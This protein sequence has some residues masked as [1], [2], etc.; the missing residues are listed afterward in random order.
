MYDS[1]DAEASSSSEPESRTLNFPLL[2]ITKNSI[3]AVV[4]KV[5]AQSTVAARAEMVKMI[6]EAVIRPVQKPTRTLN[7]IRPRWKTNNAV[8]TPITAEKNLAPSSLTPNSSNPAIIVQNIS[9]GFSGNIC[10]LN[11]GTTQLSRWNISRAQVVYRAS[12]MSHNPVEPR[13]MK[14]IM[15]AAAAIISW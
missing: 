3:A 5:S 2:P 15:L 11:Q 8:A 4:T 12:S 10:P 13:F 7:S 1:L 14:K 6:V 9:G